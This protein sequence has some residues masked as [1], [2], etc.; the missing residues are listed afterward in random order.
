M[1]AHTER[2][3]QPTVFVVE[4]DQALRRSFEWLLKSLGTAVEGFASAEE[5]LQRF[6]PN[7]AGCIL[8]DVRLPGMSGLKLQEELTGREVIS[9]VIL[10]TGYADV[11]MAVRALRGGAFDFLEKPVAQQQLI[12]KIG[13]ALALDRRRRDAMQERKRLQGFLATL[14][15]R[16]SQVMHLVASGRSNKETAWELGISVK[17]VEIHRARLMRKLGAGSLAEVVR[18]EY[19]SQMNGEESMADVDSWSQLPPVRAA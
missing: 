2:K 7:R 15:P 8:L 14:S 3:D 11:P 19:A 17:T 5:F 1:K 4:D 16:E 18:I 10:L 9:P 6:D 12:D 13:E